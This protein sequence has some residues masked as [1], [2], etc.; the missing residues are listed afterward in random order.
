MFHCYACTYRY[1]RALY[2]HALSRAL[3]RRAATSHLTEK[4]PGWILAA[5]P[6]RNASAIAVYPKRNLLGKELQ[7]LG[8]PLKLAKNTLQ[9][10]EQP[11][12]DGKAM[13]MIRMASKSMQCIVSWNH[14]IDFYMS[15]GRVTAAMTTY[16]DMKKR[17]QQPDGHTYT[18]VLRGLALHSQYGK[19]LQRALTVYHSMFAPDSRVKPSIIHTNAAIKVCAQAG[20]LDALF[21]VAARLPKSGPCAADRATFT[22]IFNALNRVVFND[23]DPE[24]DESLQE[25]ID[26]RQM[27]VLQG[28][29]MWADIID[30]WKRGDIMLD[31]ALICAV[32]RLLLLA[33]VPQDLDDVLSLL[34]Q[35]M[36]IPRQTPRRFGDTDGTRAPPEE[37]VESSAQENHGL[38]QPIQPESK[39][40]ADVDD[41]FVP[42]SEFLPLPSVS[43]KAYASPSRSTLSLVVDACTRLKLFSA[44]QDYWG[45]LTTSPHN[46]VPDTANY[47]MYLRLLRAQRA[48]R[49]SVELVQEMRDGLG[50]GVPIHRQAG[51]VSDRV[52]STLGLSTFKIALGACKRDIKNPNVVAHAATLVR[53]MYDSLPVADLGV[54]NSYV[55][56]CREAVSHDWREL[57]NALRAT[58]AGVR[59]LQAELRFGVAAEDKQGEEY[60][61]RCRD[62]NAYL[63]NLIGAY[64]KLL[65]YR[66]IMLREKRIHAFKHMRILCSW[67]TE[68][69]RRLGLIVGSH[70]RWGK[71]KLAE[72]QVPVKGQL[73]GYMGEK[74]WE[75]SPIVEDLA[76][77]EK[78]EE[79]EEDEVDD[80]EPAWKREALEARLKAEKYTKGGRNKRMAMAQYLRRIQNESM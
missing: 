50:A 80:A 18:I 12:Q 16:N 37:D 65:E 59:Q 56:I 19:S 20:D 3:S 7:Y 63:C 17:G 72:G 8:D 10:L 41:D 79:Q 15:K 73:N 4:K 44:A 23:I 58:E 66:Y 29:R 33:D 13:D 68:V 71:R 2:P 30:R 70:D 69:S 45:L 26:K 64:D 6:R 35:T 31:E 49:R 9:L 46:I 40:F 52:M 27:A 39:P 5:W 21:G 77:K 22:T 75:D 62:I 60:L 74:Q 11:G 61:A 67:Q 55:E 43:P 1:Y 48:S 53:M 78:E 25:N 14:M 36:G 42:G 76:Q 24:R 54:L 51:Q 38:V 34:E 28:R 57:S 47:H 32:G